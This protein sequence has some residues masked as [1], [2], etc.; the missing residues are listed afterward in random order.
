MNISPD[1]AKEALDAVQ[2]VMRRTRHLIANS[3]FHIFLIVTGAIWIAGFLANQFLSDQASLL[4]WIG[5]SVLGSILSV[6]LGRRADKRVC[7][8][9]PALYLKRILFFWLV[10]AAFCLAVIAVTRP[11]DGNELTM[12]IVLFI[13][14]GQF[15]MGLLF[16]FSS[17]WWSLPIAALALAGY[18]L[19]AEYFYLW[20][21][22]LVGGSMIALG[23]FIRLRW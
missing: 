2:K 4:V 8:P 13:L 17:T 15:S 16:S 9:S 6:I 20:M 1:E 3:G 7:G 23:F 18:F 11:A 10:L 5:M 14:L 22:L 12:L 19:M 21:A